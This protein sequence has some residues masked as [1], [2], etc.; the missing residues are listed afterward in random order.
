MTYRSVRPAAVLTAPRRANEPSPA[1]RPC[2]GVKAYYLGEA[3]SPGESGSLVLA[4][5]GCLSVSAGWFRV[6]ARL[7]NDDP[8]REE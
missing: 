8:G 1:F 6:P 2:S 3:W 7:I 4:G 5:A